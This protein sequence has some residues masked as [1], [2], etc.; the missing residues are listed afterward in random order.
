M[1]AVA[2]FKHGKLEYRAD[3]TGIVHLPFGKA[4][5][6]EQDL[7][8]NLAAVV[9]YSSYLSCLYKFNSHINR[10]LIHC[11]NFTEIDRGK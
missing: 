3:K 6:P 8:V 10:C 5:F 2:E 11:P 7:L 4:N 9:V 1:Q